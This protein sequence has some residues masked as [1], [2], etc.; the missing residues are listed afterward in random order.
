MSV[1]RR[2]ATPVDPRPWW[3]RTLE[4][5]INTAVR[6]PFSLAI[7]WCLQYFGW[8]ATMDL[9]QLTLKQ[10]AAVVLLVMVIA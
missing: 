6:Y 8:T 1:L 10:L 2:T 9:P 5:T 3:E 7:V 4:K